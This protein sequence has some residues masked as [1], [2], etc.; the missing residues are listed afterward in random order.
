M[1]ILRESTPLESAEDT[2]TRDALRDLLGLGGADAQ[3]IA[4]RLAGLRR[5]LMGSEVPLVSEVDTGIERE[6]RSGI[7]SNA[8]ETQQTPFLLSLPLTGAVALAVEALSRSS[9]RW[10]LVE[11][12]P[13]TDSFLKPLLLGRDRRAPRVSFLTPGEMLRRLK[14]WDG[15]RPLPE[16]YLTFPDHHGA[17]DDCCRAAAFFQREHV[18]PLLELLLVRRGAR[19][20]TTLTAPDGNGEGEWRLQAYAGG[21]PSDRESEAQRLLSW[22]AIRLETVMR[23]NPADCLSWPS[24]VGRSLISVRRRGV[25]DVKIA[26]GFLRSW[27]SCDPHS[28]RAVIDCALEELV[29]LQKPRTLASQSAPPM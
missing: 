8:F 11:S 12:T 24:V 19:P 2:A 10:L 29:R 20:L 3:R 22:L 13:L 16:T 18:F 21:S 17:P 4:K 7:L 27:R 26:E 28:N 15:E 23:R 25:H 5:R 9:P 14:S 1:S 6:I